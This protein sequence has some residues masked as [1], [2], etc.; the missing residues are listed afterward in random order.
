M[1]SVTRYKIA[2]LVTEIS[3]GPFG[4][5]IKT[6]CFVDFG[7]PVL[8]GSNLAGFA[9]N[10]DRFNYVSEAKAD[11]LGKANAHRGDVIV[12][13]RG[14]LGQI[15]YIPKTSKFNR[16]VISQSQFRFA[17]NDLVLP[18]YI[19]YYFHTKL[20]QHQ[21]LSNASQ[22][23]VP[24]LA[25]ATSTFKSI[26]IEIPDIDTQ[27]KVVGILESIERKVALNN[28][29]NGCL[30]DQ[31][32][33]LF[34]SMFPYGPNDILPDGWTKADLKHVTKQLNERVGSRS[35]KVLSAINSGILVYSEDYFTKQVFSKSI[36]KYI[37]VPPMAF[38]YNPARVNIGSI[39]M[40]EFGET[41]C[42]SPVYVAFSVE[43]G[44]EEFFKLFIKT[45]LFKAEAE[46]RASGSVRQS[47]NYGDFALI[48][49][50]YPPKQVVL[51]FNEIVRPI[52][53]VQK[54]IENENYQLSRMRDELLPRL[55]SG[56]I[57]VGDIE[58]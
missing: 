13:H 4:S 23:G 21:L 37:C 53:S 15:V 29:I 38:A 27:R 41:G 7:I 51:H 55:M 47:M 18:E 49:I 34:D 52:L 9:L 39:G 28:R 10:E 31:V 50:A 20:G 26:Q 1:P 35:F 33:A 46:T 24:A 44:Y 16:Y 11:S 36:D 3:M 5:N 40:N 48:E 30:A 32:V 19:T 56:E 14:T 25:R 57:D 22:V 6:E 2:D 17:C 8:N 54:Q 42:V 58:V 43:N 12:T 45:P